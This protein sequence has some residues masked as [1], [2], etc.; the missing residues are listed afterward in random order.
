MTHALVNFSPSQLQ[1]SAE[2]LQ[3]A[4]VEGQIDSKFLRCGRKNLAGSAH[5][6]GCV[7]DGSFAVATSWTVVA[8]SQWVV[9]ILSQ[10]PDGAN[11]IVVGRLGESEQTLAFVGGNCSIQG[12]DHTGED[13]FWTVS[14]TIDIIPQY[15]YGCTDKTKREWQRLEG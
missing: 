2:N 4:G 12:F 8:S 5:D 13:C 11:V 9:H 1:S 10:L 15:I 14:C 6:C 3:L 7:V